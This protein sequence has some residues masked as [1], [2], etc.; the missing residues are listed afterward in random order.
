MT[1]GAAR[2]AAATDPGQTRRRNEDA[3]VA[4]PPLFAVA[5]GM[6]GAQA[7]EI[8]ARIAATV[9][10]ESPG[11]K[12]ADAVVELIKEANRRVYEAAGGDETRSGM[13]TTITAAMV[14]GDRVQIGHVGDSR[15]YR[16]REGR[17]E[18][19]T[20]D[21]SL[22]AELV[23]SGRLAPEEADSHPQRSVITRTVGTDPDVDVDTFSV[24]AR[25]GDV[26]FICSDGLTTMVSD[27]S[28]LE[29]V[30]KNRTN[31]D[32]AAK[33][34]VDAANK[35]GG[36]DNITIVLFEVGQDGGAVTEATAT[37]PVVEEQPSAAEEDTLSEADRVPTIDDTRTLSRDELEAMAGSPGPEHHHRL[38]SRT[39]VIAGSDHP[40]RRTR[41][42]RR[43]VAVARRTSSARS[44]TASRRS[45]RA[46]R[47]TSPAGS[48]S[49]GSA[50]RARCSPG[51]SPGRAAQAARP[52]PAQL[53]RH[54]R[55]SRCSKQR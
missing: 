47:G 27:A 23:R 13:G 50:T 51:S 9:L 1:I 17:L 36:E 7:G 38:V 42:A 52:R 46:S 49:T 35:G 16:I 26:F 39:A 5:D 43:L 18:Q 28:I 15:A 45:T 33:A 41:C 20:E 14:E 44:R 4:D 3:Y 19:L 32:K 31:L 40:G 53:R 2:H 11:D 34:L 24:D 25:P 55:R 30:E 29:L 54:S 12:G 37:L 22:V 10:R 8:A 6:G 48:G 21:H